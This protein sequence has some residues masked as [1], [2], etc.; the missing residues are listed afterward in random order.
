MNINDGK[1]R[2]RFGLRAGAVCAAAA[3]IGAGCSASTPARAPASAAQSV[4]AASVEPPQ[5]RPARAAPRRPAR[6]RLEIE[7][8]TGGFTITEDVRISGGVR[9]DYETALRY[10]QQEQY[11]PGIALLL[12]I[13]KSAPD[14]TAPHIDLGI[15][16]SRSDDLER[17]EAS[18]RIALELNPEHPIAHNELGMVYRKTGRFAEARESYGRALAVYPGF[19]FA[20]RNLA[21]LC[22][23][24]LADLD[25][26]LENYEAYRDANPDDEQAAMWIT[27]IRNRVSR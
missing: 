19:H 5:S 10:L 12:E 23:L 3:V 21:I 6:T 27:D 14:V 26:A 9:A 13:T 24:Y 20:R 8:E 1:R 4:N 16:Y 7:D 22:D 11:A 2:L 15:A 18:L 17:A 25:C